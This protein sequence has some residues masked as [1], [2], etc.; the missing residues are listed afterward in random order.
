[1]ISWLAPKAV[2]ALVAAEQAVHDYAKLRE[3]PVD[4]AAAQVGLVADCACID[5]GTV[6]RV[7]YADYALDALEAARREMARMEQGPGPLDRAEADT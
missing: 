5:H 1:M 2:A 3:I 4:V 6:A 7:L